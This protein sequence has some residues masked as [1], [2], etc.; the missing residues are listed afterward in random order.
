MA[1]SRAHDNEQGHDEREIAQGRAAREACRQRIIDVVT[2]MGEVSA[3]RLRSEVEDRAST[4]SAEI[5]ALV[6]AGV[7]VIGHKGSQTLYRLR[8]ASWPIC[9]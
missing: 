2:E 6:N 9:K 5:N 1:G 8:A 7:L 4:V 3:G